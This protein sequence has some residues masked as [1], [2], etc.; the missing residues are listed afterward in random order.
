MKKEED[1]KY[2]KRALELAKMAYDIDEVPIG[3][4]IVYK[5]KIIGEGYNKR[6][7][8]KNALKHAEILAINQ[9]CESMGDWRLEDS[10]M[11]VTVEPCPMCTGAVLQS[12]IKRVVFGTFNKKAGCCGSIYN[13]LQDDRFNHQ[14]ELATNV[15]EDEC[16]ELMKTFFKKL[17]KKNKK[18]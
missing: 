1:I 15:L 14:V 12:R 9:A 10:T 17:R 18:T 13:M 8:S 5:D 2:M 11:Y 16:S 7:S 6:N 4:V 3:C